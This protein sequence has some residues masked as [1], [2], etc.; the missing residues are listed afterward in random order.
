MQQSN[1]MAIKIRRSF[2]TT[3]SSNVFSNAEL[4][5]AYKNIRNLRAINAVQAIASVSPFVS[6]PHL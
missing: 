4:E 2:P 1:N 3:F 5:A 6:P